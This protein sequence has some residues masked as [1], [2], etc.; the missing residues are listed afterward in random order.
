MVRGITRL[1][2]AELLELP[3]ACAGKQCRCRS[4]VDAA[5]MVVTSG[6]RDCSVAGS[7]QPGKRSSHERAW[8]CRWELALARPRRHAVPRRFSMVAGFDEELKAHSQPCNLRQGASGP[9]RCE[10]LPLITGRRIC[11]IAS[12]CG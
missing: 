11:D 2:A 4:R 8:S 12:R 10:E 9:R 5:G 6:A 7:A 1:P 3:E